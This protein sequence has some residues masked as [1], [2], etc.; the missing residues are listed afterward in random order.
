MTETLDINQSTT[1]IADWI[2]CVEII[3]TNVKFGYKNVNEG[4]PSII[5]KGN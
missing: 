2:L 3:V 5:H 1:R 4:G